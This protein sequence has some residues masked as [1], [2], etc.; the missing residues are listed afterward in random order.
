MQRLSQQ[1]G[2]VGPDTSLIVLETL[3][4]YL[5]YAIRPSG[6]ARRVRRQVRSA[7]KRSRRC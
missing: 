6:A 3:E 4:D 2:L 5:R 1:F 7:G